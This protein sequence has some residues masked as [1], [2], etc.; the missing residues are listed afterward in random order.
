MYKDVPDLGV[1][2]F[3]FWS[4]CVLLCEY[5]YRQQER[6]QDRPRRGENGSLKGCIGNKEKVFHKLAHFLR[7]T[8]C[9]CK[10]FSVYEKE[11]LQIETFSL[12]HGA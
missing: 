3:L 7:F 12:H 10:R 4:S 1:R 5:N 2:T 6:R 8:F 11:H 9:V